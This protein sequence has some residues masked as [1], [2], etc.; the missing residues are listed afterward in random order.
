MSAAMDR[1]MMAMSLEEEGKPFEMPDLP[2]FCSNE[3]NKLSLV[4][5]TLNPEYQKMS[6]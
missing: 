2:G 4:G 3:K 1:V 6:T 5:R